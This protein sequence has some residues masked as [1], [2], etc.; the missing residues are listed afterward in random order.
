MVRWRYKTD[1][2]GKIAVD[3]NG[4]TQ[5]ISNCKIVRWEDG[6]LTA[7]VGDEVLHLSNVARAST[8][9][10]YVYAKQKQMY[11]DGQDDD[12]DTVLRCVGKL[13]SRYSFQPTSLDSRVHRT[14]AQKTV[15]KITSA[16]RSL[17]TRVVVA[18]PER[19]KLER[20]AAES[21]EIRIARR[22]RRNDEDEYRDRGSKNSLRAAKAGTYLED[23]DLSDEDEMDSQSLR[24]I[25]NAAS[26]R[27]PTTRRSA[28]A[29]KTPEGRFE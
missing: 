22:T 14:F 9:H 17:R 21:E 13:D 15:K 19:E 1:K 3:A 5:P 2:A 27:P 20:E 8:D 11:R 24:Q 26:G 18:D 4:L 6:S 7:Y 25:K 10:S 16:G 28:A 29:Q 12:W 23:S